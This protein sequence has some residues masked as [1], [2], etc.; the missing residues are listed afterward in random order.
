MV[1]LYFL[2]TKPVELLAQMALISNGRHAKTKP[3]E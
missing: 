3:H 2:S 1:A